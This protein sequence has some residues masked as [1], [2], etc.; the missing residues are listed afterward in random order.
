MTIALGIVAKD[1]I[2]VAADR[3]VSVGDSWKGSQAR[4]GFPHITGQKAKGHS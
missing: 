1:G 3:E 4:C 2:V